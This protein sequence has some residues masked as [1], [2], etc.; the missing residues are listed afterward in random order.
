MLG[1][2]AVST[3]SAAD[4]QQANNIAREMVYRCGFSKRL[5]PVALMDTEDVFIG[6]SRTRTIANIGTEL[7]AIAMA[8]IEEVSACPEMPSARAK[9]HYIPCVQP[10]VCIL[11]APTSTWKIV[12]CGGRALKCLLLAVQLI[13]GVEAKNFKWAGAEL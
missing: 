10:P 9:R 7:A 13:E 11:T 8:D 6:R 2:G 1:E 4:L 12:S 3:A 5:G